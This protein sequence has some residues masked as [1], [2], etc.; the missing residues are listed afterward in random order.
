MVRDVVVAAAAAWFFFLC[1]IFFLDFPYGFGQVF[2]QFQLFI[3]P[4]ESIK[5][6]T[7]PS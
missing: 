1:L 4:Y 7:R 6:P 3:K 2:C 5:S